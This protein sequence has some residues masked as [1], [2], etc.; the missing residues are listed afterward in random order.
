M[1]HRMVMT[2]LE[3]KTRGDVYRN[4]KKIIDDSIAVSPW[5]IEDILK[6]TARRHKQKIRN[7][8]P[9]DKGEAEKYTSGHQISLLGLIYATT[10]NGGIPKGSTLKNRKNLQ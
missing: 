5:M 2:Y 1:V 8:Q 9:L 7:N 6:C 4:V 10:V 3:R